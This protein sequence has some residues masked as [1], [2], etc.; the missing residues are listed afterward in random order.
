MFDKETVR[1]FRVSLGWVLLDNFRLD[2]FPTSR[3]KL[4]RFS[5]FLDMEGCI[6]LFITFGEKSSN[7]R[8]ML[9]YVGD[10]FVKS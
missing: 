6:G 10:L 1:Q 3:K 5:N 8:K 2:H 9:L 4:R 7:R